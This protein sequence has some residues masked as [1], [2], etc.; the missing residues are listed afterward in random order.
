MFEKGIRGE[1]CH[2]V[3]SYRKTNT[4]LMKNYDKDKDSSYLIYLYKTNLN[5]IVQ[6]IIEWSKNVSH[7]G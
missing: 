2:S 3:L 1:I 6:D 7:F 4:K 5:R